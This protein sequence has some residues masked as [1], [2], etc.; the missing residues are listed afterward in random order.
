MF[1]LNFLKDKYKVPYISG[2]PKDENHYRIYEEPQS[3]LPK[4]DSTC[5]P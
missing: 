1:Y 5:V 4:T 2:T 3:T